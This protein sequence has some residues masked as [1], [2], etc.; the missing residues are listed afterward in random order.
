MCDLLNRLKIV[1]GFN[2]PPINIEIIKADEKSVK[3]TR[4]LVLGVRF[5]NLSNSVVKISPDIESNMIGSIRHKN[6]KIPIDTKINFM[7]GA[8][9]ESSKEFSINEVSIIKSKEKGIEKS[10]IFGTSWN[11]DIELIFTDSKGTKIKCTY[12]N[13]N[14]T[15]LAKH[16]S[17]WVIQ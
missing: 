11:S 13:S 15:K 17:D 12:P 7:G 4:Y 14:I 3:Q 9:I 6:V 5:K 16:K 8:L 2:T 1:F 10:L